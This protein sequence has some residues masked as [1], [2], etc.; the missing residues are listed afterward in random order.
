M[1]AAALRSSAEHVTAHGSAPHATASRRGQTVPAPLARRRRWG[2]RTCARGEGPGPA[3]A[4]GASG[5]TDTAPGSPRPALLSP[6][7]AAPTPARSLSAGAVALPPLAAIPPVLVL[8]IL[9]APSVP[10]APAPPR[11]ASPPLLRYRNRIPSAPPSPQFCPPRSPR[12]TV[13]VIPTWGPAPFPRPPST[14]RSFS[15]C[16]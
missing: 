11:P 5:N 9:P 6:R 12:P 3:A 8:S 4:R 16:S 15:G 1:V 10:S 14:P 7:L 2:G 13:S